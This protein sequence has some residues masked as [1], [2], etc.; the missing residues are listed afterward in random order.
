LHDLREEAKDDALVD[1]F[2]TDWRTAGLPDYTYTALAFAE[3]LTLT[4][5]LMSQEDIQQLRW[6]GY[7][8]Q[9][10]HD[11]VQIAAY[12]NYIN[13]VSD[14]LGVPPEEFMQPWPRADGL[15]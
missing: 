11:I 7:T 4:P 8:D 3:K 1:R 9:E 12:F 5:S 13:R 14:A 6:L 10:I 15:W 2:A